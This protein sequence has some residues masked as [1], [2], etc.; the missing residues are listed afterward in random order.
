MYHESHLVVLG[1]MEVRI[2]MVCTLQYQKD[3]IEIEVMLSEGYYDFAL[4]KATGG[5]QGSFLHV[6]LR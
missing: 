2:K 4:V 6:P 5:G 1:N 3:L